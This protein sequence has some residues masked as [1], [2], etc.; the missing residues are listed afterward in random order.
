M[1]K[2]LFLSTVLIFLASCG[3]SADNSGTTESTTSIN[4][5]PITQADS[6]SMQDGAV[7]YIY[8]LLN[9]SDPDNDTLSIESITQPTYGQA[10]LFSTYIRYTPK[11]GY[12]GVDT[13]RYTATD[14]KDQSVETLIQVAVTSQGGSS[15]TTTST[16]VPTGVVDYVSLNENQQVT[17]DVL[18]ND[19]SNSSTALTIKNTIKP[20]HGTIEIQNNKI[21]YTPNASY[22]GEDSFSYTPF[23]GTFEGELTAVNITVQ[24]VNSV[25]HGIQDFVTIKE[26]S[27]ATIDVLV[28]DL[29]DDGDDIFIDRVTQPLNGTTSIIDNKILYTPNKNYHGEDSF[30]YTPHDG[31]S[32]GLDVLVRV[33]VEDID[34]APVA[35]ADGFSVVTQRVSSLDLLANDINNDT[36]SLSIKSVTSPTHG[37]VTIT[38]DGTVE[39][40]SHVGYI[41]SDSFTYIASDETQNDSNVTQVSINVLALEANSAPIANNDIV[42][43]SY[44]T[45]KNLIAIFNNDIDADGDK[46]SL[47]S[48]T[49]PLHGSVTSVDGGVEYTPDKDYFGV[50]SFSYR[51]S[52]GKEAGEEATVTINVTDQNIAPVGIDDTKEIVANQS[53]YVNVLANDT[54]QNGDELSIVIASNPEHGTLEFSQGNL[55]YTPNEDYLGRDSFTYRPSDGQDEGNITNVDILVV[56]QDTLV[57]SGTVTYDRIPATTAGLDYNNIRQDPARGILVKLYDKLGNSLDETTTDDNGYYRFENLEED[58]PYKVR[59]YAY[60]K[61]DEWRVYVADNTN[62]NAQYIMEGNIVELN[63]ETTIRNFNAISGWDATTNSYQSNRVSAPFAILDSV[64]EALTTVKEADSETIFKDPFYINWSTNNRAVNGDKSVGYIGTS[65]YSRDDGQLWILGDANRDTDE[66]DASVVTHE[67]GHFLKARLSR[68]D[69]IGGN[70]NANSKLDLRLAYEEGWCNAFAGMV[71]NDPIYIDTTGALQAYSSIF[72]LE[73]GNYSEPGWFNEGSIH[74]ILYDLFDSND[75]GQDQLSLG[76]APLLKVAS[77]IETSYPAFLSIFTFAYGLKLENPSSAHAIDAILASESI[78]SVVDY[79]G[80]NQLNDGGD[81]DALPIYKEIA[82]NETKK[83]CT[84]TKFGTNNRLL[85]HVLV[86]VDIPSSDDYLIKFTQV[87]AAN[88]AALDGDADFNVYTTTPSFTLVGE[89]RAT[90][91]TAEQRSLSL[92]RGLHIIDLYDANSATKSCFNLYIKEDTNILEDIWDSI[93]GLEE[94]ENNETI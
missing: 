66:F 43:I 26:N 6:I 14:G 51:P 57:I 84:E 10:E 92:S 13:L 70:H 93:F 27:N 85:N 59:V 62:S 35:V 30:V 89:A 52:D 32:S 94:G 74:R 91:T 55:I 53:Y 75:D 54:D 63:S 22:Q 25:P 78:N 11:A 61:S 48:L 9:D 50:D 64:Y 5:L 58:E 56:S 4:A 40:I 83:F 81:T 23:N 65:H 42:S 41:G 69:S 77:K 1:L 8:P 88:G 86:K 12:Q 2:Y 29:D 28:N 36:D 67:F 16:S 90:S 17:I 82:L 38:D 3:S 7:I 68:Q 79:Y 45:S 60:L 39:Y 34:Y 47:Y 20:S 80:S 71:H 24:A 31:T 33:T 44:N 73:N 19:K 37:N 49:E 87:A 76:F 18:A 15:T 46:I 21:L 72:D